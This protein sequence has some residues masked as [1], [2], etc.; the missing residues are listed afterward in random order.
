MLRLLMLFALT[1]PLA[2]CGG[3]LFMADD[4]AE[5]GV[6][7]STSEIRVQWSTDVDQR[8]P[9]DPS[10]FSEPVVESSSASIVVGGRDGRVH[11]YSMNGSERRRVAVHEAVESGGIALAGGL[12]VVGDVGGMLYGID[13][14][15]GH[16]RWEYQLSS[17]L[18]GRPIA[19]GDDLLLQTQDNRIYR[20]NAEGEKLWSYA[21]VGGGLGHY[22][23]ASP[24]LVENV[25]YVIF[26]NGDAV[27]VKAENGDLVWRRQL[28]L[29]ADAAVLGE[30]KAPIADPVRIDALSMGMQQIESALLISF[31][32]GEMM[33]LSRVDGSQLLAQPISVKS[34]P[35]V[36]GGTLFIAAADGTLQAI[37]MEEGVVRWTKQLSDGELTGPVLDGGQLWLAG[38]RGNVFRVSADGRSVSSI[39]LAGRI[40]RLPVVTAQGV[41]V[42]TDRGALY[43]LR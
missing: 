26:S 18:V 22:L 27:A 32:Q 20:M 25:V 4:P 30:L 5:G 13:P 6:R 9:N 12:V 39:N 24:L 8:R 21:G 38:D 1:L 10:G 15:Q 40:D 3:S 36:A 17:A 2:S 33:F 7:S 37:N 19:V 31:Y 42:R 23:S 35:L 28:L 41:L 16:I 43:M 29:D 11:I 34:A 14:V